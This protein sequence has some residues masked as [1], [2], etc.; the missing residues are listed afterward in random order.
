MYILNENAKND[1][2]AQLAMQNY[3]KQIAAQHQYQQ[4][5]RDG[6]IKPEPIKVWNISDRDWFSLTKLSLFSKQWN[7]LLNNYNNW[8][9]PTPSKS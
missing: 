9:K 6:K 8:L 1:P 5:V 4:Q 7:S 3:T 2:A